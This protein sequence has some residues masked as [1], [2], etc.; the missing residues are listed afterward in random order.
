MRPAF[1]DPVLE[2]Q[3]TFRIVLD[4]VAHPGRIFRAPDGIHPPAPL[5]PAA[6]A[7]ALTLLDF[8]SPL[9]VDV[10]VGAEARDWL[11]FHTG[12]PIVEQPGEA[13]FA[14]VADADRLPPLDAFSRGTDERPERSATLIVQV[15]NLRPHEGHRLTG[16]GIAGEIRL[17][18]RGLPATFWDALR[19][20]HAQFPRGVDVLLTAGGSLAAL[21][22]TTR[23][24]HPV[25]V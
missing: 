4:A 24:D 25:E 14:L 7:L 2:S 16:P 9:W 22:R 8:E 6:A 15:D 3:R 21:P 23:V 11:R 10:T 19:E 20:N 1:A 13:A 12:A 18:V 5:H 17:G